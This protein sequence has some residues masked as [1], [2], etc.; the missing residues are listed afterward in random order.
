MFEKL[1]FFFLY[2]YIHFVLFLRLCIVLK[3]AAGK[4]KTIINI[5]SDKSHG[6]VRWYKSGAVCTTRRVEPKSFCS[7]N[8]L[9]NDKPT[10]KPLH[11]PVAEITRNEPKYFGN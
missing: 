2:I 8:N 5:I 11:F 3:P 9:K 7:N 4:K 1:F 10:K 6:N